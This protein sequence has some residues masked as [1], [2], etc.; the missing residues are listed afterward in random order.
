MVL[1]YLIEADFSNVRD[2]SQHRIKLSHAPRY[3]PLAADPVALSAAG[4]AEVSP[5][6]CIG[7]FLA[8]GFSTGA[9]GSLLAAGFTGV[10][11]DAVLVAASGV[12]TLGAG[13]AG[14]VCACALV[15]VVARVEDAAC[16]GFTAGLTGSAFTAGF[17]ASA[18]AGAALAVPPVF[19]STGRGA[20][21]GGAVSAASSDGCLAAV[22]RVVAG[23]A[24]DDA[25]GAA[26]GSLLVAALAE[27]LVTGAAVGGVP[28]VFLAAAADDL[29][30]AALLAAAV[31]DG[32][33]DFIAPVAGLA[34]TFRAAVFV[35]AA[36]SA[37]TS[38][39]AFVRCSAGTATMRVT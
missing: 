24:D 29:A 9:T 21:G 17:C 8:A 37:S 5:A 25:D 39:L 15:R 13:L 26:A 7:A 22:L 19:V 27:G 1:I 4:L 6:F 34:V 14:S 12:S 16:L 31:V 11:V 10:L 35:S 36:A 20:T 23:L 28:D 38:S 2:S 32:A 33:D 30:G 3:L 18:L